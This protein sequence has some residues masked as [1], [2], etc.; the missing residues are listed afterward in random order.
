MKFYSFNS[1]EE[2]RRIGGSCFIEIQ[3]CKIKAG[4]KERQI[5]AIS[6]INHWQND[7]LYILG[8]DMDMFYEEYSN[9]FD[10]GIYNNLKSGKIDM[11]GINY[12]QANSV[13]SII[14]KI[15]RAQPADYEVLLSWLNKAKEYNG[16]YI[17][18]V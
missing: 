9:I 13:E 14:E 11:F 12:Y 3:F 5:V 2:R 7:S 17:L 16:F 6:K 4:A 10:C 1:Q 18:G 8:D 15:Q